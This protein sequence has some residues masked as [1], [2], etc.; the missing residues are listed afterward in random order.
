[1]KS[2]FYFSILFFTSLNAQELIIRRTPISGVPLFPTNVKR[3]ETQSRLNNMPI[4]IEGVRATPMVFNK[5]GVIPRKEKREGIKETSRAASFIEK[6]TIL[7]PHPS[8]PRKNKQKGTIVNAYISSPHPYF[9]S[10]DQSYY[11]Y[12]PPENIYMCVHFDTIDAESG[13]D[14]VFVYDNN[15]TLVNTYSGAYG[16]T[17]SDW[18]AGPTFTVEIK[19]DA[20]VTHY[21]FNVDYI[22][23]EG[24]C[25]YENSTHPYADNTDESVDMYGPP[26][27]WLGELSFYYDSIR[28]EQDYDSVYCYDKDNA[29]ILNSWT[30]D[31]DNVWSSWATYNSDFTVQPH[32][33]SRLVSDGSVDEYGWTVDY[34]AS[35]RAHN[36]ESAHNY[37]SS[38]NQTY[39]IYG[40]QDQG[41]IQ[42]R[43]HFSKISTESGYDTV[44]V[45]DGK[46]NLMN[47]YTGDTTDIW[48][49]WGD[50]NFVRVVLK[51]D[52]SVTYWGFAVD[53]YEWQPPLPNITYYTPTGWSSP[54]V[55]AVDTSTDTTA[56][57]DDSLIAG[58]TSYVSWAMV[59]NGG[60]DATDTCYYYL[61]IDGNY[62][63]GWYTDTLKSNYY[64][65]VKHYAFV[66]STA[67]THTLSDTGDATGRITETDETDNGYA[68]DYYWKGTVSGP[69]LTYYTPS[70]WDYPIV[71]SSVTGTNTVG[72]L[73]GD[74]A[75]YIDWAIVNNGDSTAKPTFYTYLYEDGAPVAGWY[76]DSLKAGSYT[77]VED[78]CDTLTAGDHTLMTFT[79][80][81]D[82]V[83][84]TDETDNKYSR[85]FTWS[86]GGGG[87]GYTGNAEYIIITDTSF[88]NAFQPL[89]Y[90][91]TKEGIPAS[92]V[93]TD[94]I[95]SNYAGVDNAEKVR[96]FI[97]EAKDSGAVYIL[98][99]GQCDYENGEEYVARRNAF[100]L[101]S[102]A[103]Y[104]TDEDTIIADLYFS[105]LDGT[106]DGN[107]NGTY[108]ETLD[109]VDMYPDI[110]VGRAPVKTVSQVQNFV[111]KI[112]TYEKSPDT[113]SAYIMSSFHPQGNLWKTNKGYSMPDSMVQFDPATWT[114]TIFR[115]DDGQVSETSVTNEFS[116]GHNLVH[117][118]GHGNEVGVYYNYG[119]DVM[120][121]NTDADNLSNGMDKL[122]I[123]SSI[124]CFSGAMDEVSGGDC[125][126][127]HLENATNGGTVASL[128][129]SRYGW[130]YSSPEGALGPSGEQSKYFFKA[131]HQ[132]NI[133]ILGQ[134]WAQMENYMVPSASSDAY[135]RWCLY[136]RNLLGDPS[137]PIWTDTP[138]PLTV[139]H[140]D[141]VPTGSSNL[142]ITVTD[143]AKA[144]VDNA[145]VTL[146]GKTEDTLYVRGYTNAN[147]VDTLAI[148]PTVD[149]DTVW[150]TVTKHNYIPNE[151]YV[152]VY[153]STAIYLSSFSAYAIPEGV[154][155]SWRMETEAGITRYKIYRNNKDNA[156]DQIRAKSSS[157]PV[158]YTYTDRNSNQGRINYW[159]KVVYRNGGSKWYGPYA[160]IS[161]GGITY[162]FKVK[163]SNLVSKAIRIVYTIP[164]KV[165]VNIQ[166]YDITGRSVS[167]LLNEEKQ[168][169]RYIL[170]WDGSAFS[171]GIYFIK[172]TAGEYKKTTKMIMIK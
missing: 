68:L 156:I 10:T 168:A 58:D 33:R 96:N 154:R 12:G 27:D 102:D 30:G 135:F 119:N 95:Y 53:Q 35:F 110:Y 66:E 76:T 11:V 18:G 86:S 112:L 73:Y 9:N 6:N 166:I 128:F 31:T 77:Y 62:L 32:E 7:P 151:G 23:T 145:L 161:R 116:A 79:D 146:W 50:S 4:K 136:E 70:G 80:S 39:Y 56:T 78:W 26:N 40:P 103:G 88:V 82:T 55:C 133:Y 159:L 152:T 106:W 64:V 83:S 169:G 85:T 132:D 21:G 139:T 92:I 8:I 170:K 104:Y 81:T 34:W 3:V 84:E 54:L 160:V 127:E 124:A 52:A 91:K 17:W 49:N 89:A 98:L 93:S 47:Y 94:S 138:E 108:G 141:S 36:V 130:G 118:V 20:S 44:F 87:S 19:S 142:V 171:S 125:F 150:V 25:S 147:G 14:T 115:E 74:S 71:P 143:N 97:K 120:M 137:M 155:L 29:T 107:G 72:T 105:D 158:N 163:G 75:T 111:N 2:L 38:A 126:A 16:P 144:P 28:T 122:S 63:A 123:A 13:Y 45:Y 57:T 5:K 109:N 99:G 61:Y 43:V 100:C 117:I 134:T 129:N 101:T 140:N 162:G 131:L 22:E 121:N 46:G 1:M 51:S 37:P 65:Y 167:E 67:G 59:N 157:T 153:T 42:M 113:T 24:T 48:T 149:G 69:N 148:N 172:F 165:N 114:A 15:G 90:W 41:S 164:E 60:G